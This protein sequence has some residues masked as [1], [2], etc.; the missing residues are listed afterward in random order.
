VGYT[1]GDRSIAHFILLGHSKEHVDHAI[2]K[3]GINRMV[4]FTSPDLYGENQAY[5]ASLAE[6]GV[7]VLE[8]VRLD[9][10]KPDSLETMTTQILDCHKKYGG[11]TIIC[12]LTGGTNLM[13][14]AMA[15][16]ALLKGSRCHYV[17]NNSQND[18]LDIPFFEELNSLNDLASIEKRLKGARK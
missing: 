1:T 13:V 6:N 15:T 16:A 5:I 8:V 10:F 4:V 14:I 18:V 2:K 3:Y 9:S 11:F 7:E 17:L 12:G